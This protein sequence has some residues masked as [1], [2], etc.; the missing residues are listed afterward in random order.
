MLVGEA[1]SKVTSQSSGGY[2]G[3][4]T[5]AGDMVQKPTSRSFNLSPAFHYAEA[6]LWRFQAEIDGRS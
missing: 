2:S 6:A 4:I 3:R 5:M 1:S